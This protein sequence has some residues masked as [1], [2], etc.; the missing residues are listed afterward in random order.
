[1]EFV[2]PLQVFT[3][4]KERILPLCVTVVCVCCRTPPV[5]CSMIRGGSVCWQALQL[6]SVSLFDT[7]LTVNAIF[8][9]EPSQPLNCKSVCKKMCISSTTR[10]KYY[11]KGI[12]WLCYCIMQRF[13]VM[14]VHPKFIH[15]VIFMLMCE[16]LKSVNCDLAIC[17]SFPYR[18]M[19]VRKAGVRA[20]SSRGR[21]RCSDC[22]TN[23]QCFISSVKNS[24][25]VIY[26]CFLLLRL[27]F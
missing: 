16:S 18:G 21:F 27:D 11:L 12:Y 22:V 1:M 25:V 2:Y 8:F 17:W 7:R 14:R 20:A 6:Q 10:L 9:R 26:F 5:G 19:K 15:L 13:R 3:Q 24:S 23:L 4:A